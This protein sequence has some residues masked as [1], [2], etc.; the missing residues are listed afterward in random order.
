[1]QRVPAPVDLLAGLDT[2][3]QAVARALHGP[4]VVLA[5]AGTGKTRAVTHRIAYGVATGVHEPQRTMAI[6]FTTRAAGQ[7]RTRLHGLGVAGVSVRTFHS[8]ALRQL[9]HFWPR[10]SGN[11]FPEIL[12]TKSRFLNQAATQA[13]ISIDAAVL[14]DAA[15]DIEWCKVNQVDFA[16]VI[17]R[18]GTLARQWSMPA[19][20]FVRLFT[21]YEELK[22]A[23]GMIDFE[24]VLLATVAMLHTRPEIAQEVRAAYRW[25]TVDEFQDV[26]PLQDELLRLWLG[27]RDDVCAV[28]DANQ[29][30]YSFTG[31]TSAFLHG[32]ADQY[33]DA[34]V[35]HLTG[36]YRCT[37]Q[38]VHLANA[39][40]APLQAAGD[41]PVMAP[42]H[43][44]AEPGPDPAV[45]ELAD[46]VAEADWVAER[47]AEL[48]REGVAANRIAVLF[49]VNAQS[50]TLEAALASHAVPFTMRGAERFFE[51]PEVRQAIA[52]L[53][54][55]ALV[56][57]HGSDLV[58]SVQAVLSAM[59]WTD[60]PPEH[61][62]AVRERWESLAALVEL[63][64]EQ[65]AGTL[66]DLTDDLDR[67]AA[68]QDAPAARAV[69]LCSLHAAKGLEWEAV[70]IIG[71][72]EG[73][74]PLA[75]AQT[76]A[77]IAEER[78]LAY[79]GVTR[80]ARR[81]T[82]TWARARQPGGS[83]QRRP[84]RFLDLIRNPPTHARDS[85]STPSDPVKQGSGRP[86]TERV[87][88]GPAPCRVCGRSLVTAAERTLGR[89][90]TCPGREDAVLRDRLH[91]WR[92]V[93]AESRQIPEYLVFTDGTLDAIVDRQ[94]VTLED[95][96][97]IPGVVPT[98]MQEYGGAILA[99]LRSHAGR[100]D[101]AS[102][103]PPTGASA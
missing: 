83:A 2:E 103:G 102:N 87:R 14:R 39:L 29:T 53:R 9:R 45:H 93:E 44:L 81:L 40:A 26:N 61:S 8:A 80:A 6:T 92:L 79:V 91:H 94:P 37:P 59:G 35:V 34:T 60:S 56:P 76:E 25:F 100:Q 31:A 21:Q 52:L 20:D 58:S 17:P 88:R 62:G 27:G 55:A 72:S 30:I 101:G 1:M 46:E 64:R 97:E 41:K 47:I 36:C 67:R 99:L 33:Q 65:G 74:L 75:T 18:A 19:E 63:A 23:Q 5:G 69:T 90:R 43:S 42:L 71:F 7:M 85:R 77:Q 15:A 48:I 49:R 22:T 66:R 54:G 68:V 89:C 28:G 3:Q 11:E 95:L 70:F 10:I 50:V 78:R 24:D 13:R 73:L 86:R 96:A 16:E 82:L 12:A 32:F 4:V 51:R 38:I 57:D 84:S 98:K